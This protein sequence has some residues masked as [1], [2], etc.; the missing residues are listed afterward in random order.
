[1]KYETLAANAAVDRAMEALRERGHLPE[2]AGSGTEALERIKELIPPGASVM[3]GASR[4]LEEIGFVEYLQSGMHGWNNLHSAILAETD[5]VKKAA[6]RKK[7]VLSDFY[8][9][10]AHAVAETGE[11]VVASNTGSQLPPLAFTAQN[12]ILVVGTQKIVPDLESALARLKEHV[13]PL[14][15]ARMRSVGVAAGTYISKLL[16]IN[17]E[18]PYL[19]RRSH[20]IFVNE[21]LGF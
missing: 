8:A 2:L 12:I 11:I 10:S 1:M 7:A 5:P 18:Q 17:K 6:L 16:I 15:D 4:T 13:L 14:E 19:G 21:K 9:G 3:N 20:I